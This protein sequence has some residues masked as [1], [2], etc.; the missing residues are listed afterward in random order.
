[1]IFFIPLEFDT[2]LEGPCHNIAIPLGTK[3]WNGGAARW[4]KK[5]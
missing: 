1:V 2:T 4:W 3:N 5:R